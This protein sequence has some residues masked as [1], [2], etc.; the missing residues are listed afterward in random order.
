MNFWLSAPFHT[1]G[2]LD[3]QLERVGYGRFRDDLGFVKIA[4]VLDVLSGINEAPPPVTYP[5]FYPPNGGQSF[6]LRQSLIE[7]PEPTASCPGF[8]KPVGPPLIVQLGPGYLTPNVT[9]FHVYV[10]GVEV[11][12]CAFDE[13]S[14]TNVVD[15]AQ[16]RGRD[17]LNWRDAVVIIPENPFGIGQRVTAELTVNGQQYNWSFTT[18]SPPFIDIEPIPLSDPIE[19]YGINIAGFNYG[20]QTH[21]LNYPDL[22]K[23][24]GMTWVKYQ[25]KWR[26]DSKPEEIVKRLQDARN[27]GFKVLVSVTGILIQPVLIMMH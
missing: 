16:I 4:S 7:Y 22:M 11:S 26:S 14:Y 5:I 27:H 3:P 23:N 17:L 2:L 8:R 25:L 24:A 15:H 6:V 12:A 18:V 19:W 10:D 13:T 1:L 20:G 21:D 9:D